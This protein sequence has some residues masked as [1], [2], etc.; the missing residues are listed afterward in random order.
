MAAHNC[1]NLVAVHIDIARLNP[2]DNGLHPVVDPRVQAER[3]PIAGGVDRVDH[4]VQFG[5]L[6]RGHMQHRTKDFGGQIADPVDPDHCGRDEIAFGRRGQFMQ[7]APLGPGLFDVIRDGLTRDGINHRADVGGQMPWGAKRQF[8]H[9]PGQHFQQLGRDILL[10]I[11]HPCGGTALPGGPERRVD[12]IAYRMFGQGRAVDDHRIQ[13]AGFSDQRRTGGAMRGHVGANFPG[14]GGGPGKGHAIDPGISGQRRP[15]RAATGQQ[16]QCSRWHPGLVQQ[17]G[18]QH[19]DQWG[20]LGGLGQHR[21]ASGQACRN[22]PGKNRQR[23]VPRADA[24]H[25]PQRR[26]VAGRQTFGGI[27]AQEISGFAQFPHRVGQGLTGLAGQQGK[28]LGRVGLKG[29]SGSVQYCGA[30]GGC[31]GPWG[32]VVQGGGDVG[33]ASLL[34]LP[35]HIT[36]IRRV[37]HIAQGGGHGRSR[38]CRLPSGAGI[39]VPARIQSGQS[40]RMGQVVAGGIGMMRRKQL[41]RSFQALACVQ[42]LERVGG[43]HGGGHIRID[44][45]V[46]KTGIRPVFQQA[47]HQIGQQILVC[48]DGGIYPATG[49]LSRQHEVVQ[50][51]AHAVQPLKLILIP[52]P[53][54]TAGHMQHGGDGMG[55]MRRELR[56]NPVGQ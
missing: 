24:G 33:W 22:L 26:R 12:H 51:V 25:H 23:K 39:P 27:I 48:A 53:A 10:D 56:I 52:G 7:D 31:G 13:P 44:D 20:L 38:R 50:G 8:I 6:E 3:Q 36:G 19:R 21:I 40:W 29:V 5:G 17:P 30:V 18:G 32:G 49:V 15:N 35:D 54:H 28:Y 43:H 47:A 34:D 9:R 41:C 11:Q 45:L 1:A 37:H 42:R 4:R 16:M 14:G 46:D 2:V 55:V